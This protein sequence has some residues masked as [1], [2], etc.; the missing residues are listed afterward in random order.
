MPELPDICVYLECLEAKLLGSKLLDLRISNP[1]LLRS[2]EPS[3]GDLQGLEVRAL[4]RLGKR[5]VLAFEGEL[6]AVLHLMIAGRLAWK[7]PAAKLGGKNALASFDFPAGSLVL[8]EA[9]SKRRASLFIVH[10]EE[11]LQALDPGGIDVLT[12]NVEEFTEVLTRTNHTLKR[13]LTDPRLLS[14][15]GTAYSAEILHTAHLSP[16]QLTNNL[17][18]DEWERLHA[19][20]LRVLNSWTERLRGEASSGWPK[21]VTAFRPEMAV[22]GRFG[23]PCPA[24]GHAVQRIVYATRETNYCATCQTDGKLLADR[25]LSRLLKSD[26]PKTME[27]L[28]GR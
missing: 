13:A 19:A 5:I 23:K 25:A 12:S 28:E 14:G 18:G 11:A 3:P 17:D 16:V 20:T 2:V 27:E 8:T 26:W 15:I 22:H 4:R 1:F 7:G 21:K 9:G 6:F 24:C 10:G